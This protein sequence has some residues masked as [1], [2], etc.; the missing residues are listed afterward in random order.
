MSEFVLNLMRMTDE[1]LIEYL[2]GEAES[3]AVEASK[4]IIDWDVVDTITD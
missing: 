4:N 2:I 3:R 1:E